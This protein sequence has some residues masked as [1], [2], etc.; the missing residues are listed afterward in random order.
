MSLSRPVRPILQVPFVEQNEFIED[1]DFIEENEDCIARSMIWKA[2]RLAKPAAAMFTKTSKIKR[3]ANM[4][5]ALQ[6]GNHLYEIDAD[7]GKHQFLTVKR[8]H[9][10]QIWTPGVPQKT[11]GYCTL[12][13]TQVKSDGMIKRHETMI[14]V[15]ITS[16][17]VLAV[18]RQMQ[19][20]S[21]LGDACPSVH[22][23]CQRFVTMLVDRISRHDK[24][25]LTEGFTMLTEGFT[26][27][28]DLTRWLYG[29]QCTS[30][31][32]PYHK[33]VPHI[34]Q[35][36]PKLLLVQLKSFSSH[37]I[38]FFR[39]ALNPVKTWQLGQDYR[40]QLV[41]EDSLM[42]QLKTLPRG[43]IQA[44]LK[45]AQERHVNKDKQDH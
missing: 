9:G 33:E 34:L 35:V 41:R 8:L 11:L 29:H 22:N 7:Q 15:L 16:C 10:E 3:D 31:P 24:S 2:R 21:V 5:W 12:T 40:A 13:D 37:P 39:L 44:A 23:N 14:W 17:L 36:Y 25:T 42:M 32:R 27:V 18:Q 1:K 4:Q 19:S 26:S 6:I 28:V 45:K 38:Q 43:S 20:A 30:V